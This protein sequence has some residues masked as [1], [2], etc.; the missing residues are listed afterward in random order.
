MSY[1]NIQ[2][3][4]DQ[5]DSENNISFP[6]SPKI[7]EEVI[8]EI[9]NIKCE[10]LGPGVV[11]FRNAFEINQDLILGYI[12]GKAEEAHKERWKYIEVD[13]EKYGINEDGF[14]YRMVD[15]PATPVRLLDPVTKETPTD[16][17]NFF[18]YLEDQIYKCLIKYIDHYP[19]MIG[20]IWWKTRGHILR[21]G[22][23]GRLGCHADNDTNYKVTKGVRYMPKGMVASRQTC[24]AL[25]YFNDNVETEQELNG[26]NFTGGN[27]RFVHLG[28]SYK[29]QKGDIIFFPTNYVASHDVESMG[30][31]VRYSYLTFFGQGDN[32]LKA[33]IVVVE[34]KKSH[35][36]CPPVWFDNI[37]DDY[38]MYCKS[39]YSI[40]Y[41]VSKTGVEPGWN[42][43]FQGR[44]VAQYNTT[45]DAVEVG[46]V[47]D[48]DM[49]EVE[50][51]EKQRKAAEDQAENSGPCNTSPQKI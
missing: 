51:A 47:P 48:P 15:V 27:L 29:P 32:D 24:G 3:V 39:K 49:S 18:Y 26:K 12:D 7:T 43:V 35:K 34:E 46:T 21:Y 20:S 16:V 14:R 8:D 10:I 40:Y 13:G 11:V 22:D 1:G 31:G 23:G 30:K 44:E 42:P 17:S 5:T 50:T 25:V 33:G 38:E 2:T 19:L 37:Y 45:H 36:W 9:G 6:V 4:N 41:D 28:I